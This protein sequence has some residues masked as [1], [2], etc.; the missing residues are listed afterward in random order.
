MKSGIVFFIV[1]TSV[2][3]PAFATEVAP[4]DCVFTKLD[5][6]TLSAIAADIKARTLRQ[7]PADNSKTRET[8]IELLDQCQGKHR[9]SD[10]QRTAA[11]NYTLAKVGLSGAQEMVRRD[12]FDP[13]R[14]EAIFRALPEHH[15][16]A[17]TQRQVTP[18][19]STNALMHALDKGNIHLTSRAQVGHVATLIL[20]ID[21]MDTNRNL[22]TAR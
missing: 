2:S 4:I 22:L 13:H 8:L 20:E 17:L 21:T 16:L 3:A 9:W 6:A 15:R 14:V 12:G 11:F 19:E 5:P 7:N 18:P 10:S 1:A